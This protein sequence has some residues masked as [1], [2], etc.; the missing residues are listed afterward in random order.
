MPPRILVVDDEVGMQAALREVLQRQGY[1]VTVAPDAMTALQC[2]ESESVDLV[3]TDV[4]MP[5]ISGIE[6]LERARTRWPATPV[7]VMTAYGT[8]EDA[9]DAMKKGAADYLIKPFSSETVE[10]IVA[11][12]VRRRRETSLCQGPAADSPAADAR[13]QCVSADPV[14]VS[15]LS[16]EVFD[17]AREVADSVATILIQGDSGTGKEVLARYIHRHSGRKDRPFV[18]V[19]CAA[20]PEGLLESELFGHEKGAFTGA[21][22]ARKGK[23]ELANH[24]TLLL[25]EVSEMPL[26]LQ[27]KML[28]VLQEREIDPI[29]SQRSVPLD[30]RVIAT[31]NRDLASHVEEGRFRE[32]LYYRLQVI[33]VEIPPLRER[34]E[35]IIPLSEFFVRRHCRANRRSLKRLGAAVRDH[36]LTQPWRGNVRELENFLERAVLLCKSEEIT[37]ESIFLPMSSLR[38]PVST[39]NGEEGIAAHLAGPAKPVGTEGKGNGAGRITG[40][41][42][43]ASPLTGPGEVITLEEMERRLILQT[44]EQV[45]GNRTRAA[46]LLGVSVRTIRNKLNLY[47]LPRD[48]SEPLGAGVAS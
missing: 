14:V 33:I 16:R 34:P 17:L 39:A 9:V 11:H 24:G 46:S 4:R 30:V 37:P 27:A 35:D 6:L 43:P 29:G 5:E 41:R 36:L 19:N 26:A 32:D 13:P 1:E 44:L 42:P 47:S 12:L 22:L 7:L 28:R 8:I 48:Q 45:G 10:Q 21:V 3:I 2:L 23:F 15:P 25:D 20:L 40:G 38:S 18:A 31:T